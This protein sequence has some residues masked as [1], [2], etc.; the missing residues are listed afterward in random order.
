MIIR[1]KLGFDFGFPF[2]ISSTV[3]PWTASERRVQLD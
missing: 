2:W 3:D 1:Q